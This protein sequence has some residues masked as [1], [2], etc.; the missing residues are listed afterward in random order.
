MWKWWCNKK[1]LKN[2]P[3]NTAVKIEL[4]W[5]IF[6]ILRTKIQIAGLYGWAVDAVNCWEQRKLHYII[7]IVF[8]YLKK[9][10]FFLYCTVILLYQQCFLPQRTYSVYLK[11]HEMFHNL[12]DNCTVKPN[13]K[14]ITLS[15]PS[16]KM[17]CTAWWRG[18]GRT[19][20]VL[21][22]RTIFHLSF[23]I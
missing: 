23:S 6:H 14:L 17:Y 21:H 5:F 8:Q 10:N 2:S 9:A 13:G 22:R 20:L 4:Q 11:T 1:E 3:D 18:H 19:P 7:K 16:E 12:A 15:P